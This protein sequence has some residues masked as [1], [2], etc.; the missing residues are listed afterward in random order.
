M[1]WIIE[2]YLQQFIIF[3]LVL[4]RLGGLLM[5]APIFGSADVPARVRLF[6]SIALA[7]LVTPLQTLQLA[8]PPQTPV[9]YAILVAGELLVGLTV[10][11]GITL[12]FSGLQVAGQIMSQMSGMQMASIYNPGFDDEVPIFSQLLYYVALGV[13]VVINGHRRVMAALLD[14]FAWLPPGGSGMP[15]TIV[16]T[17]TTLAAQSFLLGVQTA[18]PVM[19]ALLLATLVLGLVSRT[20]PQ[21]NV[22]SL[23]FG[24]N[25]LISLGAISLSLGTVAWV[26]QDE[27][28]PVLKSLLEALRG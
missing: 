26:F 1:R 2:H 16:D 28:E 15:K 9:D 21:L 10:G 3:T 27:V 8:S 20:L 6:L 23:G 7:V 19:V 5:T 22:M 24:F 14:T 13:F 17:L 12:L 4:A 25:S 11:V 18:A